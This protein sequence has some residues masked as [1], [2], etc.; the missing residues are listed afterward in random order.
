MAIPQYKALDTVFIA[1]HIVAKGSIFATD[2]SPSN[3][4]QPLNPEA[5]AAFERWYEEEAPMLNSRG[6]PVY[7]EEGKQRTYKP[8]AKFRTVAYEEAEAATVQILAAPDKDDMTGTLNMAELQLK[9][10]TAERPPADPIH[11]KTK[12]A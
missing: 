5:E 8:H 1:P 2:S 7:D 3:A 6:D 12:A 11:T 9:Q 10:P 4:W